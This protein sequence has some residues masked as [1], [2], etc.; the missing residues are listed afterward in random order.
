[1]KE[2]GQSLVELAISFTILMFLISGA[3]EFGI[4]FFQYVQ[5]KDAVQEGA[6]YGSICPN[7]LQE[8][9]D[10]V[11]NASNTP[12]DLSSDTVSVLV[13]TVEDGDAIEVRAVYEHR[14]F[15]PFLPRMLG[16]QSIV[17][18]ARVIDTIL[19]SGCE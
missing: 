18:D 2:R 10:R 3:V 16:R 17:L 1:M 4:I 12:I 15:M 6:L 13:S 19:G 11:R 9:E 7:Q 5:L 14:I 8:I